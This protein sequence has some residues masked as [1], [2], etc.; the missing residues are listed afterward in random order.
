MQTIN[1][2][3]NLRAA[4]LELEEKR[5]MDEKIVRDHFHQAYES[6][7]PLN[8]IKSTFKEVAQSEDIKDELINTSIGLTAGYISKKIF[9]G[10]A[11]NPLKKLLGTALM[12][13]VKSLVARNPET[14]KKLVGGLFA[15]VK[16]KIEKL[17]ETDKNET[18]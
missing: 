10:V 4:I 5:A 17:N 14:V 6:I 18:S 1:S 12:F 3:T 11:G 13:G 9:E 16:K 8:L 2:A 7:K 15:I